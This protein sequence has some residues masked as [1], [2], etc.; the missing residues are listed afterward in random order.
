MSGARKAGKT[1][2]AE[3]LRAEMLLLDPSVR[4]DRSRVAALLEEGF[5]EFGSSGRVWTREQI[6]D[7]LATE[8]YSPPVIEGFDC[9]V[10]VEGIALVTYRAVRVK[11]DRGEREVTLRSSLW[12]KGAY[13]W[14]VS[15]HQGTRAG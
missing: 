6:L 4:R 13:G 15:F 7:L 10:L 1:L 8:T 11:G 12:K 14:R 3:L 9:L 5:F 2:A